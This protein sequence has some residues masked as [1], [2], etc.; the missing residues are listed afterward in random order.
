VRGIVCQ[1]YG[2][3]GKTEKLKN[4]KHEKRKL[5]GSFAFRLGQRMHLLWMEAT[6]KSE[7]AR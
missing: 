6:A 4:Q 1:S 3:G 5:D 7:V 2:H